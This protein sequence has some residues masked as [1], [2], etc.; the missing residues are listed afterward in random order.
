MK[1]AG[2]EGES[3]YNRIRQNSQRMKPRDE[4]IYGIED[5][6]ETD[7]YIPDGSNFEMKENAAQSSD[8]QDPEQGSQFS[9]AT[10]NARRR[11]Q[12]DFDAEEP[13]ILPDGYESPAE[14]LGNKAQRAHGADDNRSDAT[15]DIRPYSTR[16]HCEEFQAHKEQGHDL[17]VNYGPQDRR[18]GTSL[19]TRN[20]GDSHFG[21]QES[22]YESYQSGHFD[23]REHGA[24]FRNGGDFSWASDY[25]SHIG[26]N[27]AGEYRSGKRE[28]F[29]GLPRESGGPRLKPLQGFRHS[30]TTPK[31]SVGRRR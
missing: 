22:V 9:P 6:S 5:D 10:G 17:D 12:G 8:D 28:N 18:G 25:P 29:P 21:D 19:D 7:N 20:D 16:K 2:D 13:S 3:L 11:Q 1:A 15:F 30:Y 4:R 31:R 23:G 24:P 14:N 26:D 27:G